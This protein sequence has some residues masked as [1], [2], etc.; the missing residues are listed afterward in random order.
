MKNS[1]SKPLTIFTDG[2]SIRNPGPG[3]WGVV[4]VGTNKVIELGGGKKLTTNNEME[5]AAAISALEFV[6]V[7]N[8]MPSL[9]HLYTDSQYLIHGITKWVWGWSQSGWMTKDKKEVTHTMLW[10]RLLVLVKD[11]KK[12]GGIVEWKHV[13]SHVGM[14]GNERAD[15]IATAFAKGK[16]IELWEGTLLEYPIADITHIDMKIV[17]APSGSAKNKGK[18]YSYLSLVDGIAERHTTW[19]ECKERVEGKKAKFRK[20]LSEKNEAEILKEW[21]VEL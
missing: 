5:L 3:G 4:V 1:S 20:A 8:P 13:L 10:K 11:I 14:S 17:D 2:S 18:A 9:V 19:A 6:L 12:K 15:E 16:K 7:L 21:G